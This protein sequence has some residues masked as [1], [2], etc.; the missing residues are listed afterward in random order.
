M[1]AA[2]AR[3]FERELAK[4]PDLARWWYRFEFLKW[5][6]D[7]DPRN[8]ENTAPAEV[9]EEVLAR[10]GTNMAKTVAP[11][12]VQSLMARAGCYADERMR[13]N[14]R[15]P[16]LLRAQ[17]EALLAR[18]PHQCDSWCY[19]CSAAAKY[20]REAAEL[21]ELGVQVGA[22]LRSEGFATRA[23]LPRIAG[24]APG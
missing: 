8:L 16:Q 2:A 23:V 19:G 1:N 3:R 7:D 24:P 21:F 6:I 15:L 17:A 22:A 4:D 10:D 12:L 14:T 9:D 20:A 5:L 18:I 11:W 13:A